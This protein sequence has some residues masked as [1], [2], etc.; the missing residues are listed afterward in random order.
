MLSPTQVCPCCGSPI[1]AAQVLVDVAGNIIAYQGKTIRVEC[2]MA[3][4]AKLLSENFGRVTR[5][6]LIV[7][8]LWPLPHHQIDSAYEAVQVYVCKLR[9]VLAPLGLKIEACTDEATA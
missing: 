1:P 6:Q 8:T 9:K 5:H 7:E 4:L 3:N 2:Q